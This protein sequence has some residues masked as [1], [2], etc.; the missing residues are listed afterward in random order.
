[1]DDREGSHERKRG[2]G[3][4]LIIFQSNYISDSQAAL[5]GVHFLRR[6]FWLANSGPLRVQRTII[7]ITQHYYC[8]SRAIEDSDDL[9]YRICFAVFAIIGWT[10]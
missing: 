8:P 4:R 7:N 10:H 5:P 9:A 3:K 2:G 1:M 6:G